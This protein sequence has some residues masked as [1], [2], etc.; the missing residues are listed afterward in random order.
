[1]NPYDNVTFLVGDRNVEI[2]PFPPYDDLLC[3][4]L[5][6]LSR[7]LR[8]FK[9]ISDY[10]DV[11]AFAFWCRKSN[12]SKLKKEFNDGTSRLGLGVVF[13]IAPSNVPVNFAFSF[14]FGL[15]SGNANIVRV[16]TKIFPQISII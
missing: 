6:D 2:L 1:M 10:P 13:H 16:P 15:L 5:N 4:F 12:I 3:D 11:M 7:E 8:S 14:V 9:E